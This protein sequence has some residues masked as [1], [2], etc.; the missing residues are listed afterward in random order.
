M[1]YHLILPIINKP[2]PPL[3]ITKV[4]PCALVLIFQIADPDQVKG[5]SGG[6]TRTKFWTTG[7]GC[8]GFLQRKYDAVVEDD[9]NLIF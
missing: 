9:K 2:A 3:K 8:V 6:I 4:R 7:S 5:K 1:Y